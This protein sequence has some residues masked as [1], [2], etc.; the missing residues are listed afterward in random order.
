MTKV[1]RE[2]WMEVVINFATA[3]GGCAC[4]SDCSPIKLSGFEI[5]FR[6]LRTMSVFHFR[7]IM[8]DVILTTE[9][10]GWLLEFSKCARTSKLHIFMLIYHFLCIFPVYTLNNIKYTI[11]RFRNNIIQAIKVLCARILRSHHRPKKD[12]LVKCIKLRKSGC[13]KQY[14]VLRAFPKVSL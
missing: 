7:E 8:T 1:K 2:N 9:N 6:N 4:Q 10:H 3:S 11:I 13:Y 5:L 14:I 12:T